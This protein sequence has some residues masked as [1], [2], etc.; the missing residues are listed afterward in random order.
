M[1]KLVSD[2]V[3]DEEVSA[4]IILLSTKTLMS[5]AHVGVGKMFVSEVY[6]TA[7]HRVRLE[8]MREVLGVCVDR[9]R[10]HV[11]KRRNGK[12]ESFPERGSSLQMSPACH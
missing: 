10:C 3:Q 11:R 7:F 4:R 9:V 8:V 6:P 12:T 2:G 1:K 5:R